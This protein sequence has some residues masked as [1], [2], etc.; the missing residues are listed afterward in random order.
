M[1]ASAPISIRRPPVLEP[2]LK[3]TTLHNLAQRTGAI[4]RAEGST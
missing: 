1:A 4:R 3:P 2:A